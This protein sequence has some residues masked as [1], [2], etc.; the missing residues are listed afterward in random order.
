MLGNA[1][2]LLGQGGHVHQLHHV[3]GLLFNEADRGT[4]AR[5]QPKAQQRFDGGMRSPGRPI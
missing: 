5:L 2:Q 3:H 4:N 1:N